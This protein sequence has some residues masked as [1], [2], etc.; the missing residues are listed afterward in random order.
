MSS[1]TSS[2]TIYPKIVQDSLVIITTTQLKQTNSIFLEH[3]KY[4]LLVPELEYKINLLSE[5]NE[6]LQKSIVIKDE[7]INNLQDIDALNQIALNDVNNE[8]KTYKR[9]NKLLL[10]GGCTLSGT[11]L[12][13]LILK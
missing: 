11:L 2:Q 1:Y 8:L 10:I 3:Q 7:Q 9:R 4:S 6:T 5:S 12:F 13:L